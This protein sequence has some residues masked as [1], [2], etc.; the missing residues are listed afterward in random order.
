MDLLT[1]LQ[2]VDFSS[3]IPGAYC[4]KLLGDAGAEVIK[5][6]SPEGDRLRRWTNQGYWSGA[7]PEDGALFRFLHHG[8]RSIVAESHD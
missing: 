8:H 3:G 2:V 6:E 7:D 1:D 5:V 4:A